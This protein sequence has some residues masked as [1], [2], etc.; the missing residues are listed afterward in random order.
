MSSLP[1]SHR[2]R[3]AG[4]TLIELVMVIVILAVLAAVAIPKFVDLGADAKSAAL[5]S[6]AGSLTS[7]SAVNYAAR[8]A[9]GANG[10]AVANCS[11]VAGLLQGGMPSGYAITAAT[12]AANATVACTLTQSATGNTAT[13][14]ATGIN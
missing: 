7:A 14:S 5:S 2:V 8:K 11:D 3:H 12:V 4:F 13:F 1:A 6:V 10:A 9:N